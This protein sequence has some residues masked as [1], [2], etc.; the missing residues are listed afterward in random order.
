M[1]KK[2]L[3]IALIFL[4]AFFRFYDINWDQGN[5]LHP[6]ERF[7]TMVGED[8][9]LPQTFAQYLTP[10]ISPMNPA[11][12]GHSFYV[13]GTF[14]VVVNK[15]LA[16][17][18]KEDTYNS[19][20]QLGRMLSGFIDLLVII[21]VF[22]TAE[23]FEKEYK[24]NKNV[25]YWGAF[26]YAIAVLPI[27]LAHFFAVDTF[28]N[29]FV[30]LTF[31]FAIRFSFTR[32]SSWLLFSGFFLGMAIASKVTAIFIAPLLLYLFINAY[33]DKRKIA[34]QDLFHLA[35]DLLLFGFTTYLIGRIADPYLFQNGNFFDLHPNK[36]FLDNL[37]LLQ[38]W[39]SPQAW[40]PP[41]VQWIHKTPVLFALKNLIFY[42]IGIGY[43][44]CV[45]LGIY[46]LLRKI[47]NADLYI[48]LGWVTLFFLYQSMQTTQTMRYFLILYPF[49]ALF[50]GIG[51][52]YLSKQITKPVQVALLLFVIIWPMFFFSIY[53]KPITRFT[54]S[55]WIYTHIPTNSVILTE[56][57][58][59]ALPLP[60]FTTSGNNY[61]IKEMPVF[62]P[63]TPQKWNKMNTLLVQ[64]D[65]L[66]FSS[67][68]GWGSIPTV[69]E[70]YPQMTKFYR[71]IFIGKTAYKKVA[72][73]TSY[74]SLNY[75]GIPLT[76]PDDNAEEAFTV[77]DHPK[78]IIFQ[79][80][81]KAD[82]R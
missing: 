3:L 67:N 63:D 14:P 7:L 19:F 23:L 50:A 48:I 45:A 56:H 35:G 55:E 54:A 29:T 16:I 52:T 40:F 43:A 42:G 34:K 5:H 39:S 59:D 37:K 69:P 10:Q 61:L 60:V 32:N 38:A 76:I 65:Y 17:M 66:I 25:K 72:E 41:S 6:D 1:K 11:N 80:D 21:I 12:I 53:T 27:Q 75:L 78:V 73:F 62:D 33:T 70:R 30:F 22:K 24:L 28:L 77:I 68:R 20:T 36:L 64:G 47:R 79:Q 31:Y 26:F 9:K 8:M 49:F 82:L 81:K 18:T 4:G 58:D 51:F 2:L 74:P 44:A 15:L 71:D 57:W 13:Y 46:Y